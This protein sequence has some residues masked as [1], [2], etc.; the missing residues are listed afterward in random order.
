[1][2][3]LNSNIECLQEANGE[4]KK[5]ITDQQEINKE[6][7]MNMTGTPEETKRK[8]DFETYKE[9]KSKTI[10]ILKNSLG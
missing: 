1:M 6:R 9:E 3:K 5:K 10:N 8:K 2:S 4:I 7:R